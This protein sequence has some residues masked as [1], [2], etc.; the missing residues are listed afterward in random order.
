MLADR[1]NEREETESCENLYWI[2]SIA[3]PDLKKNK[4]LKLWKGLFE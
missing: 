4:T 2:K 1:P 3:I